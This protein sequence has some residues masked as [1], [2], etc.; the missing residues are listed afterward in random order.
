MKSIK[1][2]GS[3]NQF[4]EEYLSETAATIDA[5]RILKEFGHELK[6]YV[7]GACGYWHIKAEN[8]TRQCMFCTDSALFLK[9]LYATRQ[10]AEAI[11]IRMAKEKRI[12]LYPYKCPHNSGWHLS[13]R[14]KG[15]G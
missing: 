14:G 3:S 4:L 15:Y 11:A 2:K 6:P 10:D 12:K 1:C 13:H 9:D 8:K 5:E 7:C